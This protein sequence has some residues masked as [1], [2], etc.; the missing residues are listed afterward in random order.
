MLEQTFGASSLGW[1]QHRDFIDP[2]RTPVADFDNTLQ[3]FLLPNSISVDGTLPPGGSLFLDV[4]TKVD[5]SNPSRITQLIYER[6]PTNPSVVNLTNSSPLLAGSLVEY[7]NLRLYA[8]N[9]NPGTG[10][11]T[12]NVENCPTLNPK[13]DFLLTSDLEQSESIIKVYPNPSNELLNLQL[14]QDMMLGTKSVSVQ[15]ISL[16]GETWLLETLEAPLQ[17]TYPFLVE[18]WPSGIYIMRLFNEKK[19]EGLVFMVQ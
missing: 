18:G 7:A 2:S 16:S 3:R 15:I 14:S 1:I 11:V 8:D 10:N 13:T 5:F 17:M 6:D 4:S 19:E 9:A 12:F